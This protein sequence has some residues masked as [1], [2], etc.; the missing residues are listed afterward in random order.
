MM[1]GVGKR[2]WKKEPGDAFV[3][4]LRSE[5]VAPHADQPADLTETAYLLRSPANAR[6]LMAALGRARRSKAR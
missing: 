6:R 5:D 4:R 2:L 3:K 1:R